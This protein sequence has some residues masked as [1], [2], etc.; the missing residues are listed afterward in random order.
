MTLLTKKQITA[1]ITGIAKRTSTLRDDIHVTLCH[2]AGHAY[3]NGDVTGFTR[4][5]AATSG[6]NRKALTAWVH[7][8]GFARIQPD[9]SFKLNKSARSEADFV[10]GDAV[11]TYLL[12]E[13]KWYENEES[14]AQIAAALDVAKRVEG[15]AKALEKA[16][17]EG[18][19]VQFDE[20]AITL[21]G[22]KLAKA[23]DR[24]QAYIARQQGAAPADKPAEPLQITAAG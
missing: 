5:F 19:V 18:K 9:G 15:L 14:G 17:A 10:D 23:M 8:V 13:A 16:V 21:A 2:I 20:A 3:E 4:L 1:K 7:D 12:A 6:V 11:A 24:A 22:K